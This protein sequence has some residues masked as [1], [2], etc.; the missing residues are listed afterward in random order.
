M[1]NL[2][3]TSYCKTNDFYMLDADSQD[4]ILTI[5]DN[6]GL[7]LYP[8]D[9]IWGIGCDA[10]N[11]EAI[12]KIYNLKQRDLNKPFVI[13]VSSLKMLKSHVE[14]VH[15]KIETLLEYHKRP[16]T[17]IYDQ[18]KNLAPN[19]YHKNGSVAI[20][21]VLDPLPKS[22]IDSYGKPII[23]T[24]ANISDK[25]FPRNFG[26]ISSDIIQGVDFVARSRQGDKSLGEPSIIVK[27]DEF[28]E[29]IFL[30]D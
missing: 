18:G 23:A 3:K 11:E 8:T 28:G 24:S 9:T 27:L 20:R 2:A 21:V 4:K 1:L 5:L 7:I 16:L 17:V 13:L 6:G 25:P 22:I 14:H 19:A 15:P 26:E 10:T 12:A 29:L 30:R